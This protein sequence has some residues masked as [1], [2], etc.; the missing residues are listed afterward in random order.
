M[1]QETVPREDKDTDLCLVH[2]KWLSRAA[3]LSNLIISLFREPQHKSA[4]QLKV[5][6]KLDGTS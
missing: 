2:S 4:L 6:L 1:T 3:F 5:K